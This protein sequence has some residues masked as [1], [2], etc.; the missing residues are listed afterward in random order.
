MAALPA[1]AG[2]LLPSQTSDTARAIAVLHACFCGGIAL[3]PEAM[4][5]TVILNGAVPPTLAAEAEA[6]QRDLRLLVD[7]EAALA[8]RC[9]TLTRL[10]HPR[11]AIP[12]PGWQSYLD[13]LPAG[14]AT[15][16]PPSWT[17]GIAMYMA[18]VT[19]E[20]DAVEADA[21]RQGPRL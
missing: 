15:T 14:C 6:A 18:A 16:T 3:R 1:A 21:R 13:E 10:P 12:G 2:W 5:G 4:P 7:A 11:P 20:L 8:R 19:T 17:A 9:A